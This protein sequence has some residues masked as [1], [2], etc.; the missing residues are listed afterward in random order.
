MTENSASKTVI[1]DR[2]QS[3]RTALSQYTECTWDDRLQSL[4]AEFSVDHS[5]PIKAILLQSFPH[6][7][8]SKTI[9]KA[10]PI[11]KHKAQNFALLK[12]SQELL[13]TDINGSADLMAVWWPW[14]HGATVSIRIFLGSQESYTEET[15]TF[16]K[17]LTAL[18]KPFK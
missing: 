7:W 14:G 2:T 12:K 17:F 10:H 8:D 11:L 3:I 16:S 4:L 18:L 6:C 5:V 9:K 1:F 13:T 15:G